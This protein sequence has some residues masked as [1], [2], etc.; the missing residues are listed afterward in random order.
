MSREQTLT[1]HMME[2]STLSSV[3]VFFKR[4]EDLAVMLSEQDS[5]TFP[6]NS[7]GNKDSSTVMETKSQDAT[8]GELA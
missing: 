6:V 3:L 8:F 4:K 2:S 1:K 7:E 5:F